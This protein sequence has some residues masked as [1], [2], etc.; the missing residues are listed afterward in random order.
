M[1]GLHTIP[2]LNGGL[3]NGHT[4]MAKNVK[5]PAIR[6]LVVD[7]DES[8]LEMMIQ[9]FDRK[10]IKIA[11]AACGGDALKL[12]EETRFAVALLD[13][14]LPDMTGIELFA[15]L[16]EHN[17]ELEC[18]MLTAN[19]TIENAIQAMRTGA[20]DYLTSACQKSRT[21]RK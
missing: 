19:A 1:A 14:R 11:A 13:V 2:P 15:K 7:D 9:R 12:A 20:Y 4:H 18:I 8:L 10:G 16:K 3:Y 21:A 17:P 6:L 5:P